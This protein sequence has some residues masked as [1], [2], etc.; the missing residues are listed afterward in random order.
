MPSIAIA[1]SAPAGRRF[2]TEAELP[3]HLE[4]AAPWPGGLLI[5]GRFVAAGGGRTLAVEDPATGRE[6]AA[7]ADASERDCMAALEAAVAAQASWAGSAPRQRARILRRGADALRDEAEQMARTLTAEMGKPLGESRAE[8]EFAA[9]YLEWF[10]EE[11]V[12]VAGRTCVSPDGDSAHLV[13]RGPVG[14]CLII[15]PWNF[16]L[17]VPARGVGPA[18]AAGCTVVLRPSSL[19]PLS[20]LGLGRILLEAGLPAGVLNI[21]VSSEDGA[22]DPLLADG[23]IRKLTFTGSEAVGRHLIGRSAERVLRVSAELGGCAPFVVFADACLDAAVEGALAAKMRNGGAACT[24]AN[25]FYVERP[26][27]EEFTRRLAARVAGVRIGP[28]SR[29]GVG[30]GPMISAAQVARL[31]G[32]VEDAL[33]RGARLVVAGGPVPGEG[34][35]FAPVVLADVPQDARVM[36]E[37]IFGPV[38]AIAPFDSEAE[39]L[40]LANDH[41]AGLAAYL[42]TSDLERAMRLGAAIEAGMVG[43]NRGRVSCVAAPFGGVGHSGFGHSGGAEGIEEY[44]V[45]RYLTMPAPGGAR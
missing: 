22:T 19:T 2:V 18:L 6:I 40:G 24:A 9:D 43:I 10:A 29:A 13:V 4:Q 23:R 1:H 25:R 32:L 21:V 16:P 26:L 8:V 28:G 39:A 42:F 7:V 36:R 38:V 37:E 5:D 34:H 14:P 44:L 20:A 31:G 45:T 30:C 33:A 11:A 3:G 17:A 41:R 35:F 15:T 12:R 27:Y